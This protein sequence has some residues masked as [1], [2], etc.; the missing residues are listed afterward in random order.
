MS[1]KVYIVTSGSYSDYRIER[2]YATQAEADQWVEARSRTYD[3]DCYEVEEWTLGSP[4]AAFDGPIWE[5]EYRMTKVRAPSRPYTIADLQELRDGYAFLAQGGV[6]RAVDYTG[7]IKD[8]FNYREVWHTGGNL[9]RAQVV[10]SNIDDRGDYL[11]YALVRGTSR[12]RVEKSLQDTV[13]RL[14]AERAGLT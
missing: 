6:P 11:A 4:P 5:G 1:D 12:E 14:K 7:E 10:S 2:V 13:A 9:T 8:S 3:A